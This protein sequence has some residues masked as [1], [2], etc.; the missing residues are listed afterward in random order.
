MVWGD[1]T[2]GS[3][4]ALHWLL[5]A[6]PDLSTAHHAG[7]SSKKRLA[8]A[9]PK[10]DRRYPLSTANFNDLLEAE[11]QKQIDGAVR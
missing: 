8:A 5:H 7:R 3:P 2:A 10:R 9:P 11:P 4:V 6:A 1:T